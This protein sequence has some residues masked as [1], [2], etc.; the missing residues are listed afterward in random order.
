MR[1]A[2]IFALLTLWFTLFSFPGWSQAPFQGSNGYTITY[3]PES[4]PPVPA[5]FEGHTVVMSGI[6]VGNTPAT[7]GKR[8][9]IRITFGNQVKICPEADGAAEGQ[10][11]FSV[12]INGTDG[13]TT[14]HIESVAKAKY[15]GQVG[16]DAWLQGPVLADVDYAYTQSGTFPGK[17][18]PIVSTGGTSTLHIT[19]PFIVSRSAGDMM[20]KFDFGA[21]TGSD[22][23]K[24]DYSKAS[25]MSI[26][27]AY[28]AGIWYATAQLEWRDKNRC[29]QAVF[30]PPSHT[31]KLVP[32]GQM[33]VKTPRSK[34]MME[35]G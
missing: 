9:N 30:N 2:A 33:T 5:G 18:G 14:G 12:S 16:D 8:Y 32:G 17:D 28:W 20:P 7:A 24:V 22:P 6:A 4:N 1:R 3:N 19:M 13:T 29:V 11:I 25:D 15:K 35:S 26:A 27:L 34:P 31:L 21:V 23:R 10:G